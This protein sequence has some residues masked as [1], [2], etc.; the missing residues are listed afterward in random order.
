MRVYLNGVLVGQILGTVGH[1]TNKY[2]GFVAY[3]NPTAGNIYD[4]SD[5]SVSG[6]ASNTGSSGRLLAASLG[7][8]FTGVAGGSWGTVGGTFVPAGIIRA[9][10]AFGKVYLCDG[11]TSH[12]QVYDPAT[13]SVVAWVPTAN[14]LPV[15]VSDPSLAATIIALYRGRIVLAGLADDPQDWF[16]S[17]A[18]DPLDWNYGATPSAVM[19]VAGNNSTAGL[20]GDRITCLAPANDDL[21]VMGGDHTL[22]MMRGD[23][24]DGGRIDNISSSVGIIGPDAAAYDPSS[25]LYFFGDGVLW[26]LSPQGE[27]TPLSRGRMDK[28]FGAIDFATNTM[29]LLWDNMLHGLHIF[30]T[31]TV[32]GPAAHY[33]WDARTDSF[34]PEKYPDSYG[35]TAVLAFDADAQNDR[36]FLL[37]GQD[38]Y[39]RQV[40][41]SS[42]T[43][44]GVT[45]LSRIK[46]G[47]MTPGSVHQSFRVNRVTTLLDQDSDPVSVRVYA[48]ESPEEAVK[49]TTIA[50]S[51][52]FSPVDRYS[53]PRIS[54][55]TLLLEFV[56][57]S[58]SAAWATGTDY[59]VGSQVVAS[60]GNPYVSLTVH[61]STDSGT[62]LHPTPPGNTT[63]WVLSSFRSWAL[64]TVAVIADVTGRTKHRRI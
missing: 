2:A 11:V 61:T 55:N 63:D 3:A 46:F 48:E 33:W 59:I 5:F 23:P 39:V 18:G 44:D 25:V 56:N 13:Q 10:T 30:V 42:K 31:P 17:K 7:T 20:V 8:L 21:M 1:T 29:R 28:T 15:G 45:I 47:P 38:G 36:A 4:L 14:T 52:L 58:F 32:S 40:D 62:D 6:A 37:G 53:I 50:W 41:A 60:D 34:W 43:D 19:A 35:P 12:Y 27:L 9:R 24:A 64:E 26:R 54:G 51:H 57:D 16:M 22:W 49:S